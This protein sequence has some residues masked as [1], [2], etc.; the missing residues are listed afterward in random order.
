M[1]MLAAAP[2][3]TE[4]SNFA[5]IV[6]WDMATGARQHVLQYHPLAVE[7]SSLTALL[8]KPVLKSIPEH[9]LK[10]APY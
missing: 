10:H 1:Q 4:P 3:A 7:V 8:S 5:E 6:V 9:G 2:L